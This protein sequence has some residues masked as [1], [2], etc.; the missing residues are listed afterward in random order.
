MAQRPLHFFYGPAHRHLPPGFA[1]LSV[2]DLLYFGY[3]AG[4][5][6]EFETVI[7]AAPDNANVREAGLY[8]ARLPE[9]R[10]AEVHGALPRVDAGPVGIAREDGGEEG[11]RGHLEAVFGHDA[12]A[13]KSTAPLSAPSSARTACR[14]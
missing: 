9:L 10:G 13:N 2:R 1:D 14:Q 8:T 3:F 11:G 12:M 7:P 5:G 6:L 4:C